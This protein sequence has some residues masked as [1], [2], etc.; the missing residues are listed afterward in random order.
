MN[1]T[2]LY[3]VQRLF[4]LIPETRGF[5]IK[6]VLLRMAGA[7]IGKNVRICSSSKVIGN[8]KL[9]IGDNTWIG[10]DNIILAFAPINIGKDV[11]IAPRCYIGTGT[12]VIDRE[13]PSIAGRGENQPIVIEDGAWICTCAVLLPGAHIGKKSIVAAGAVVKS[14]AGSME[15]VGG[16]PARTIKKL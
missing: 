13:G 14:T 8:A 3:I 1:T 2:L 9:S 12:H 7:S 15:I 11:N 10:F 6:R 16:I 4:P 5:G